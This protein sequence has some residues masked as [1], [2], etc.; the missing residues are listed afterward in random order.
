[1]VYG[2][3]GIYP[4]K[5]VASQGIIYDSTYSVIWDQNLL[6]DFVLHWY[7]KEQVNFKK[8]K[9][10]SEYL[11]AYNKIDLWTALIVYA[12]P[13]QKIALKP[14]EKN[15][16]QIQ[17]QLL[18]QIARMHWY[19]QGYYEVQNALNPKLSELLP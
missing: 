12:N 13:A 6:N 7:I 16:Q 4:D 14:L 17:N 1:V 15:K 19:K 10:T 3:G 9:N 8:Y 2:G 18:A 11:A 5:L